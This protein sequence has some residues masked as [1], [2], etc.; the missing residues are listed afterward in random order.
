[1]FSARMLAMRPSWKASPEPSTTALNKS[2]GPAGRP[3]CRQFDTLCYGTMIRGAALTRSSAVG[4]PPIPGP[5]RDRLGYR[6]R[7]ST[8]ITPLSSLLASECLHISPVTVRH[9]LPVGLPHAGGLDP[10]ESHQDHL[11]D[12]REDQPSQ[13]C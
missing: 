2:A 12:H 13:H 5:R 8:D 3:A 11:I 9:A 7:T 10:L 6:H 1:M 4:C